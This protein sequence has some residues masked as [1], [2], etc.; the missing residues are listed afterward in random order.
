MDKNTFTEKLAV[1]DFLEKIPKTDL[2]V[3]LDGSLRI[4]SLIEFAKDQNIE[5]PSYTVSG[6]K[7]TVFKDYY[8]T[9]DEYLKG[10]AYLCDVLRD[11]EA[12]E[13][14][15]YEL[16]ID[17]QNE[18][19]RYI[20]PRFA[21]QLLMH[22]DLSFEDIMNACW[23]GLEKAKKEFNTRLEKSSGSSAKDD[24]GEPPFNYGIIVC[25]MRFF[26]PSFSPYYKTFFEH[27]KY[28]EPLE[29]INLASQELAKASAKMIS[30]TGIPIVAFDLAGS[31]AGYP[32][33]NHKEAYEIA[34]RNF[35]RKTVHAGEAYGPESIFQA[36]TDLHA[37]RIGHGFYLFDESK[38][39]SKKNKKNAH[40][41]VRNLA[42]YIANN[43]ITLEV[44]PT[45]NLQ[46]NPDLKGDIK[47][48]PLG[49]M[50]EEKLSVTINTDNRLVS[51]TTVSNELQLAI[52]AF[53]I[54][55]GQLKNIIAY[56]FKRCFYP[57]S[58]EIG[59][60]HV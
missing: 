14:A 7:E 6:L 53:K 11:K 30:E 40:K 24:V 25:A 38:I 55:P 23:K 32:A 50:I 8:E 35:M 47:N 37:D 59:R 36:I 2:H 54:T 9:L 28:S 5:L 60:A 34:H 43:R 29:V 13:K 56:G 42:S 48:H 51:N 19:V 41:Y 58:Y 4:P 21:P 27:H 18:G 1:K 46:T 31:E 26:T 10:F 45:S 3:H 57:G 12:I 22:S 17:S 44:C 52:N 16:A 33:D 20:E 49:K 15:S 39:V